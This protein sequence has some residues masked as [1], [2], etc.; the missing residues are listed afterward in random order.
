MY[1]PDLSFWCIALKYLPDI[2]SWCNI[3]MYLPI[4]CIFLYYHPDVSSWCIFLIYHPDVSPFL[5]CHSDVSFWC[6]ILMYLP[7]TVPLTRLLPSWELWINHFKQ[8]LFKNI[9]FCQSPNTFS[10]ILEYLDSRQQ[11]SKPSFEK[12]SFE[13]DIFQSGYPPPSKNNTI[14]I[15]VG[16]WLDPSVKKCNVPIQAFF[17]LQNYLFW[18]NL[19]KHLGETLRLKDI[20]G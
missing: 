17:H 19:A 7:D 14:Y 18:T 4:K 1:H 13:L 15:C 20:A 9:H 6:I 2:S 3:L 12:F 11:G 10:H 5:I 16:I 8:S